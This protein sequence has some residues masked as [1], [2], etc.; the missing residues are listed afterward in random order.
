M[1]KVYINQTM[2]QSIISDIFSM[3]TLC[4][5]FW[6]NHRFCGS[7]TFLNALILILFIIGIFSGKDKYIDKESE[8]KGSDN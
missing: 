8:F 6:F 3:G 1:K 4:I 5:S 7:S 2:T